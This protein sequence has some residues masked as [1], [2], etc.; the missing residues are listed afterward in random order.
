MPLIRISSEI[1]VQNRKNNPF[2]QWGER[3]APNRVE[4]I[5]TPSFDVP[6]KLVHGEPIFTV[7]SC[8]ARNVE[9]ELANRGFEIPARALFRR[10]EFSNLDSG[11][12][13]NYGTPSIYNEFAWA[14]GER[15]IRGRRSHRRG[16][17]GQIRRSARL[18]RPSPRAA[19]DH[20]RPQEGDHGNPIVRRRVAGPSL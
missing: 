19:R 1:A 8:F 14:F 3:G 12:I 17:A 7:G 6:F 16:D 13:N 2:A 18:A 9:T 11:I 20:S 15:E 4:P 10:P 5:A